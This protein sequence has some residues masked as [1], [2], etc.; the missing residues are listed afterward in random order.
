MCRV[1]HSND[2]CPSGY[3][4]EQQKIDNGEIKS[5][6]ILCRPCHQSCDE[7]VGPSNNQCMRKCTRTFRN[8]TCACEPSGEQGIS[9]IINV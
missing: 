6:T 2:V 7:C 5:G 9:I 4:Q 1:P 8:G 3:Y